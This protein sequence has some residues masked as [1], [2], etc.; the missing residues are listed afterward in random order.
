M[1]KFMIVFFVICNL[2]AASFAQNFQGIYYNSTNFFGYQKVDMTIDKAGRIW[3]LSLNGN[4]DKYG[5]NYFEN[6]VWKNPGLDARTDIFYDSLILNKIICDKSGNIWIAG[7]RGLYKYDGIN[8]SKYA[9]KDSYEKD[10]EFKLIACDSLNNIWSFSDVT[11]YTYIPQYDF[12]MGTIINEDLYK[13]TDSTWTRQ[14][15]ADSVNSDKYMAYFRDIEFD[16]DNIFYGVYPTSLTM[17]VDTLWRKKNIISPMNDTSW[18]S[19]NKII[20][21]DSNNFWVCFDISINQDYS[22][23]NGGVTHWNGNIWEIFSNKEFNANINSALEIKDMIID[24]NNNKWFGAEQFLYKY[25]GYYFTK[26][27]ML[28]IPWLGPMPSHLDSINI[29]MI[30]KEMVDYNNNLWLMTLDGIIKLEI[31]TGVKED[32][33]NIIISPDVFPNPASDF[34]NINSANII[35]QNICIYNML[36]NKLMTA[37]AE[38][39]ETRMNIESL[40]IGVYLIRI[41][42]QTKMFVK[43]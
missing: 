13:L 30:R 25:D 40:P 28:K 12:Y 5:V 37:K 20:P 27:D 38:S 17:K 34:L 8:W 7:L 35:G 39:I 9:I 43:K 11:F 24:K 10:R 4:T 16:R 26:Y 6:G 33:K 3:V 21:Y 31:I 18:S 41:G 23:N 19:P 42:E 32:N 1:K 14:L 2:S 36:G 22:M 29:N 15:H